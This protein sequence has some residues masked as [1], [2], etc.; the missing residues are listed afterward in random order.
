VIISETAVVHMVRVQHRTEIC[1]G[2]PAI[3]DF[4]ICGRR[5][6]HFLTTAQSSMNSMYSVYIWAQL[7]TQSSLNNPLIS[8]LRKLTINF[9]Q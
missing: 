7:P 1:A 5:H 9:I 4:I 2:M 8:W 6:I 3:L